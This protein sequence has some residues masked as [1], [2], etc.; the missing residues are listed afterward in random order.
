MAKAREHG[1]SVAIFAPGWV[2]QKLDHEDFQSNQIKFVS[3]QKHNVYRV[4]TCMNYN[5]KQEFLNLHVN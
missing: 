5:N 1:L 2:Y 3:I 4:L